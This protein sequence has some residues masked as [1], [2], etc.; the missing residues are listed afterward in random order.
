MKKLLLCLALLLLAVPVFATCGGGGGG[1]VGGIPPMARN[2][3]GMGAEQQFYRVPWK[4]ALT[5]EPAP[6]GVLV[7][8]WFPT[9]PADEKSSELQ[10]SRP[11]TLAA[12]K[13]V[14][15]AVVRA[16]NT[17]LREKYKVDAKISVAVLALA[18]DGSEMARAQGKYG[19]P[20]GKDEVEKL[21]KD[22][23]KQREKD[24]DGL[25]DSARAKSDHG[26]KD[27]AVALYTKV[28]EERCLAEKPAKKAAKELK[29]LGKPVPDQEG[30]VFPEPDWSQATQK[31]V[32]AALS[33]GLAAENELH[34]ADAQKAYEEAHRA[35]PG[36]PVPLRYLGE[37]YRHHLGDWGKA[38]ETFQQ[39]LAMNADPLSRAVALHG[40]G[41]MT[42]HAGDFAKGL[43]L[44]EDSL[45]AYPLPLTYRNLAV[46]WS[47]EG[48]TGKAYGYVQKALA[49][50]PE[51]E[52]TQIFAATFL[53]KLGKPEEAARIASEHE[54][55]LAASYNLAA[56]WAQ[57]G[58]RDKALALLKRHFFTY[59]QFEDVRRKEM[60]EARVDIVFA[61]LKA[62]P[63]FV[64]LT[65]LADG[66]GMK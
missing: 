9:S 26:D 21:V 56:I 20:L 15:L 10:D 45:R 32:L 18:A 12:A 44:F 60:Q 17:E 61:S 50:A 14:A 47:S 4:A 40:L 7:L 29:K 52:Y 22:G 23:I 54:S 59:E 58:Q 3:M 53:V 51:D 5:G 16:D 49:I 2:P 28:W 55:L 13:C 19:R 27:G 63:A 33:K 34:L 8:Y 66:A 41:K 48:D 38:H 35:D 43:G 1:G 36:D 37:L 25:L 64:E 24:A 42:I 6:T 30:Q 57:I 62:D 39:I 65:A 11:L 31:A 46:Y